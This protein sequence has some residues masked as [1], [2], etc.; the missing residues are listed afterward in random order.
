MPY[1]KVQK[2]GIV[3]EAEFNAPAHTRP[4]LSGTS[5]NCD[6]ALFQDTTGPLCLSPSSDQLSVHDTF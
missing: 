1:F 5:D 2:R 3:P 4:R 6:G